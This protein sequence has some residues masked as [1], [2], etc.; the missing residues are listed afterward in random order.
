MTA[1]KKASKK[2]AAAKGPA[3]STPAP[4]RAQRGADGVYPETQI[5]SRNFG[6]EDSWTLAV[7]REQGAYTM[8]EKALATMTPAQVVEEVKT[9]RL[10]GRGGAG[11]PTGVKWG[12]I[13]QDSKK[14]KYLVLNADESEPGTFKDR[15]LMELD[16]HLVLEGCLLCA[17]ATGLDVIYIYIRGEYPLSITR[18]EGAI[19]EARQAGYLGKNIL[20]KQGFTV[21]AHVHPG[22]GA[23]ICG[24][25]TGMLESL[26]GKRGHPR[27]KP[28][29]PA[30]EG[31]FGCP[32]VINN[33]ETLAHVPC[34]I[35]FGG[36]WFAG[37]GIQPD[38]ANPRALGSSGT[39]LM[40]VS[41][42]VKN[43]GVWEFEFGITLRELIY[44]YAGGPLDG[45]KVK[46]VIPGG[47][48]MPVLTA[49]ELDVPMG[50]DA[51]QKVGSGLGT[52]TAIVMDDACDMVEAC[53][54][55]AHFFADESCGQC[56]PCREGCHWM[57]KIFAR[58]KAGEGTPKDLD[59]L[60][61]LF[62]NIEGRTIC[63]LADAAVWPLRSILRK[64]R[65]EFLAQMP[66]QS[67]PALPAGSAAVGAR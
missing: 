26:E 45:R 54:N 29:F 15:Y 65:H 67:D 24:E 5:L 52:A 19:E 9:S 2:K 57:E 20:G 44:D 55:I 47:L 33:V 34:I 58:I 62:V 10:R 25:E 17:Y 39:K 59:L 27:I 6:V 28:P 43:P 7:A 21:E 64:F 38:P 60:E 40:G 12:F 18:M 30:V 49:G 46:A 13:P 8:L 51:L 56:T 48:S 53:E 63:A 35:E 42:D 1:K 31:A 14:T 32:T 11:F 36:A 37:L 3:G 50:Y 41:G 16:P 22:A 23:Y 66:G 61:H 4:A